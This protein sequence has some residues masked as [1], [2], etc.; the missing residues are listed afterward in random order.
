[1]KPSVKNNKN[2]KYYINDNITKDITNIKNRIRVFCNKNNL[3]ETLD[4]TNADLIISIGGDG[5]FLESSKLNLNAD[6]NM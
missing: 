2:K 5:T 4:Y 3:E 6:Y 1:M